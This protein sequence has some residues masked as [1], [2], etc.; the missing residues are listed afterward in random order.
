MSPEAGHP[1]APAVPSSHLRSGAFTQLHLADRPGVMLAVIGRRGHLWVVTLRPPASS[2]SSRGPSAALVPAGSPPAAGEPGGSPLRCTVGGCLLPPPGTGPSGLGRPPKGL[3]CRLRVF[4][5]SEEVFLHKT[6]GRPAKHMRLRCPRPGALQ[7]ILV[8]CGV[9][10]A[11]GHGPVSCWCPGT[12]RSRG[13][14]SDSWSG[15]PAGVPKGEIGRD[16]EIVEAITGL[17]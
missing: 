1:P 16:A 7:P 4:S 8:E 15:L 10:R 14:T 13:Q 6:K 2:V 9:A 17:E 5:V 3:E 11:G 12:V